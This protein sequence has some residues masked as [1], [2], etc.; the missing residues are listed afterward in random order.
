MK[1]GIIALAA[2]AFVATGLQS[3]QA[4]EFDAQLRALA[5]DQIAHWVS[6][7]VLLDTIRHQN[8]ASAGYSQAEIDTLDQA[9]RAE[10]GAG[11]RPTIDPILHNAASDFLR[12]R[13][14]ESGGLYTEVFVMDARGLNAAASDVTSDYWQGDEDKWQQTFAVGPHAVH[15]SEV[16][17]DES[18]QTYQSQVSLAIADPATGAPIGAVTVG[19]NLELLN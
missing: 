5:S 11:A 2:A 12:A 15:I 4:N 19:V 1:T 18:T 6:D 16:E 8:A 14:D 7:P 13:R 9:W 10:V 17:L 3:V